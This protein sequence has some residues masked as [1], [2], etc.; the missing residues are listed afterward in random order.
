MSLLEVMRAA[1]DLGLV[2]QIDPN[3][4]RLCRFRCMK[5]GKRDEIPVLWRKYAEDPYSCVHCS[6]TE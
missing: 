4:Q 3:D 2:M 1:K 5:C 6:R